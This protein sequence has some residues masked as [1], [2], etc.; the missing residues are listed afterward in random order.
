MDYL[1]EGLMSSIQEFEAEL[2]KALGLDGRRVVALDLHL[3]VGA[4][5]RVKVTEYLMDEETLERVGTLVRTCKLNPE[6]W[7]IEVQ[8][9]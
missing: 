8:P 4:I 7:A 6:C 5:P 3:E 1:T 2:V 9:D